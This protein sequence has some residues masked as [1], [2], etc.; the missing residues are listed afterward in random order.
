MD[1]IS[2]QT[3]QNIT[4]EQT[5]ASVGERIVAA[6]IDLAFIS[7]YVFLVFLYSLAINSNQA[8]LIL[9]IPLLFYHLACELFMNGQSWGKKIMKIKVVKSDGTAPDLIAYLIRWVFRI[10]DVLFLFGSIATISIILNG[11]GQRLGDI[12]AHTTVIRLKGTLMNKTIVEK[13]PQNYSLVFSQINKL[14]DGDIYTAKEVVNYLDESYYSAEAVA[15]ASKAKAAL[16]VKM[17]ITSNMRSSDFLKTVI[18]DYNCF[19]SK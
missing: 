1:Q 17:G 5:L 12:A 2:I 8:T 3:T 7:V 10:V 4:I 9:S 13:L 15:M 18:R 16:E 14:S 6:I 11:K 19:Y